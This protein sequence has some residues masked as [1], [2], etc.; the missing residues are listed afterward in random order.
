MADRFECE[1]KDIGKSG[2]F[3]H[4]HIMEGSIFRPAPFEYFHQL[5]S[6]P[7]GR[8]ICLTNRESDTNL[9]Q[10]FHIQKMVKKASERI[11]Q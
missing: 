10:T 4:F 11:N 9:T 6:P 3:A 5:H 7:D 2:E 8:E 1:D